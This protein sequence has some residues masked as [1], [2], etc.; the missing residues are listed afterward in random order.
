MEL[1][2]SGYVIPPP[3][4]SVSLAAESILLSWPA[5]GSTS[6]A[7]YSSTNLITG[8]GWVPETS[9]VQTNGSQFVVKVSADG[10]QR[11][12]RLLGH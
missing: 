6:Y 1:L 11:F 8:A 9:A 10:N 4:L 2:A 5:A 12:F 3:S 7:L